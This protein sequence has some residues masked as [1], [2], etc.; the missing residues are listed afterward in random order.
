MRIFLFFIRKYIYLTQTSY[1]IVDFYQ[2]YR[3]LNVIH[4]DKISF[5]QF[6]YLEYIEFYNCKLLTELGNNTCFVAKT[7][8]MLITVE[9]ACILLNIH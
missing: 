1:K 6:Y 5:L 8:V 2:S 9:F 7:T 3:L 4:L